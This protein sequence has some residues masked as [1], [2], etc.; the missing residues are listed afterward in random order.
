M[1]KNLK[2]VAAIV[3]SFAMAVQFGLADSYYVN[4]VEEPVEPQQEETTTAAPQEQEEVPTA[5]EETPQQ[6]EEQQQPA[7]EE[8]QPAPETKSVE[9]S[10]VAEDGTVLH[11][12]A[13]RDFN[14]DYSLK[15]DSSVMLNFDGYT[16]KDVIINNSQTVPA[17][18]ANLSVTSDL[19]SV[20]FVYVSVNTKEDKQT[21]ENNEQTKTEEANEDDAEA[22]PETKE[23][24]P[25]YPAFD[26]SETAGNVV[27]HATAAEGVLPRDSK[28]VVKR[29][30]RKAILNAV[31][32]TV[33]EKNKEMDSAVALD[34][35]IQNKDG[36]EIQPNGSVNISFENAAV[37]GDEINVYHV[38]DDASAVTEVATNTQSFD[39]NHFSIYVITGEKEKPLTTFNFVDANGKPVSTQIVKT[40]DTLITPTAPDVAGKAFVGWYEGETKFEDFNT[41]LTITETKTR[42]ITAKYENALYVYFY[43]PAGTQIMRTEKVGDHEVHGYTDVSYD[44]DS[45]HKLVG[46]AAERNGTENIA[47]KITVPKGSTSVNVYAIIKEGYWISFDSNG[48]S[49]VDSQFVLNGDKLV[50]NKSTTPTKPGYTF[51]GWYNDSTKVENGATVTNPMTLK[52]HWTAAEVNYTINYWQQ[53]VTDDKNATDAQK[54]YEYVEAVTEKATTGTKISATNSKTYKGFKYNANNSSKDVEIAGDGT[55]I[56]NV[57][58]DRVLCTVNFYVDKGGYYWSDW[59][60]TKTVTGL[61]GANLPEGA[62]DS[63]KNLWFTT[64]SYGSNAVLLTSFDFETAGYAK[65][66]DNVSENGIVTTCNFYAGS[67]LNGTIKYYNEQADGTFKLVQTVRT[68]GNSLTVHEKYEGYELYKYST[69]SNAQETAQYWNNRSSVKDKDVVNG[70]IINI[71]SK[72]KTYS[73]SYYNYNKVTKTEKSIKYTASLKSYAN[74]TPARPSELPDYYVFGGWYKDKAC[75]TKFDFN[76]EKMPNANVQIYAKWTAKKI[77]LTYN[78][79]TPDGTSKKVNRD[80]DAGTIASTV[81]PSASEI[82]G[83]S[84]AGWYYA[85]GNGHMTTKV[86]NANDAITKDTSVIGKWLY[87]GELTVVYDPGKEGTKATVPTDSN[88]YAGGAKVTVAKNATTTS[89]K[90]FLGWKLKGNLYH[91]GDA[92]EVNKDL[93]NDDNV[94][95]LTAIWGNEESSTT[96]SYNPG[97][98]RGIVQTVPVKNNESVTLKSEKDFGYQAPEKEGKEYYFAGWAT[99]MDDAN[100]G[101]ATY[102][103]GQTVHV[104]VNGEN[105]LYATW[106]EKT[107]ITLVANSNSVT[108]NGEAQSV[109]GF[110]DVADGYT[111]SNLTAKATGTNVGEYTTKIEGTAKVTKG[112]EDVTEKVVVNVVSGKLTISRRNVTL[113]SASDEKVYDGNALTNDTVTA[114]GFVEGQGATYNVTGTITNVGEKANAFEYS[115]NKGTKADNYNITK[116]EGTLKVTPVTDQVTVTITGNTGS[117]KYDGDSHEVTGYTTSFSNAL[118]TANDFEFNGTAEASR[119]DAGQTN[120]GLAAEQFTNT[121]ANFTNVEFVVTDGYS[122]VNKRTVTLT[123]ASDEKVYD[124]NALTKKKVTESEDGFAKGEGATYDVTGSQ[125]NVGSSKNTFT[126]TLNEGT[127][128]DNYEITKTEGTLKVTPI[129][130]Q[131]TVTI[132]GNT[133]SV[134]YDG[135]SHEVTGYTTSFSN[136]LYTAND[137]EFNGTAEASRT[138]AGQTDMGLAAEQFTNTSDNFTNVEFV[139][140]DGYSK[141]EKRNVTLTS[142]SDEK[143]YDGNPLTNGTV[144]AEGFVEGQGAT[145]GVT[146]S[147][148]DAGESKNTF[149]YTLNEGTNPDNYEIKKAEGTLKVTPVTDKVTVTITGNTDSVKYDGNSH[150]VTGYTTSF[151]NDLYTANDFEFSGTAEVNGKDADTYKMGLKKDQ[152]KNTSKNFTNVEFV[153]TDGQ[154]VIGKR[155][156]TLTSG[157]DSKIYNGKPLTNGEVTVTGDGFANGE[158]AAYNVTGTI[159]NVGETDNTFTY[160]LNKGTNPDNYEIKKAEG[161]LIVTADASEVVV[162]I[163]EN[164]ANIT[165][166]GNEHEAT[167]YTTSITGGTD[168]KEEDFTFNG[169][170]SVK[171]TDAG[172]YNMELKPEDFQNTNNNYSKVTFVI[173]DGTLTISKRNVTLTSASDE[174]VYD[175]NALTN[176][177]VTADGFVEGQG[178]T[179]N[180]TGTI[181][182]VGEKAN[183]FEYSLNKGTKADNYNI[184]KTEGTLKVT[185]VTDQVT[186]TITGNTGSV[187]YDGDSHEVTGYTTSFSNAL[188]TANDFEFNGTAEASRTD[189]GQTDMGLAAEQFT[190]TSDNFTNVEFV[191]TDGYSKVEKRNVTLTSASDEKVYD[192]NPLTNGTVTAE[193][194]V[195][196][197]GA[198]YKVTGTITNVG[199]KANA[200]AYTLNEGTNADNYNITKTEGT[201][202]VTPITDQVTVTITGNT[203]SVKYDGDSHEVTGYTTSFS[204]ALYTANDF[205]FNGTAEASRTDAGQTNMGL[206][207]EQFTNTS[208]NFTNVEFVVTDGYSKVN[209]RTVTLTSA[210]DEKVYDGNAL[211][212][213]KV[214]ESED[215]FAKGEGATYEFTGS[216]TNVGSSKN[217]FSYT[218]N[219]GTNAD[220]YE[221]TK[222][223]GTLKV[224][225]FTDKV[226]VTITGEKDTAVYDGKTHSVEGYKVTNISNALYKKADVQFNGTAKAEGIEV[227]TYTM[228][229]TPAQFENKSRNFANV[230]FVVNDGKLEITPKS[231]NPEDEKTGIKVTKPSDTMYNGEEQKNK[232]T[233][234]DTKTG[235]TL[236]E[237]VDYTLSYTAAVN[238]GTVEVT[239]TGIGNYTGTA[240]TSYEITKRKVTLT[241]GSASKVYDKKALT[242]DEVTVSG[243]GFAKNEGATYN[244]TGSRT[245]V[246]TSD[247]T[248]T[249]E[250]KSNTKASNYNI[251]VKFGDLIVTAQDGEVVVTITGHSDSAKYDG[252]EKT[253]SGYEVTITAGS[254]YK[255]DDFTFSGNAEVK[256]T[257]VGTY[258]MGLNAD[259][260]TNTNDNYTQVTFIVNDG[261]LTITPKS[262][263]PD[264]PNTPE[265]KKTGI[266]ATNPDDSIYNGEAHVNPLTV[267]DTKTGKDLVEN[268][269]YTLT[270]SD[271]VVNVGT[272]TVT[273]KGIGNYTGEFTKKYQITPREYTVTTDSAN[274]TYDGN[275]LTAGGTVNNLVKDETVVFTITGKQTDVGASDNTYELKFE[276]TAKAKNYTHGKDSIGQL[277]VTKK[278]IVPDGPDTPDEKKTGIKVTKPD[279]TMYNGK[280]QKNKP[281]VRDTKRDVELVEDT[282]YTL[283]YTAAVNAGTVTVTITGIGNYEGTVN[284]SYE[285]T[286]RKVIMTSAD[287]TKVYDGNALTKNKVT[288]SGNGF[289]EGEGATY[290]VTGSQTD[291][292]FS[293][294]TFSYKLNKGTLA[295][296]YTI[297]TKEG[298]LEVTPFTDKVTVTITGEKDTAVYDGKTHSVEGYKVTNISNALYKKADVQFNGTAKAEGIEVGTY[299]MKLTPAQFEN[300][301]RNF[302][303][304]EFVVNDGKLEITPKSINPEDEK[305]GI[306]VTKP[307][308]TMYNGE[309]QKNKPTV[310]DTKTG[311]TLVENVDYTLSYTAAVDA[312]TVEVTITGK[313]NYTGTAKT[314]YEITKRDVLLTSATDSKVYDKK[315][316]MN[317]K[318][319]ESGSGFVKD[320]GATYNVTGSQTKKGSTKN[321]F[322]YELK[323][324]T[325]ASNYTI[326]VVYGDLTVTAEDGE[327]V[328]VITGHKKSFE[329]DGN[330]KSVKGYDVSITKGSTYEVSDFTFNGNDE[331]K[332]TE[333]NTYPMGLKVS[334]FTNN[335]DNYNKVKF[336]VTD[337][338][339]TITPKSITP[340]GPN[341]P[342]EKKTGITATDPVDSI[343]DGKAHV[344]PLTVKDTKTNK[345]L[346]ENKDYTLTYSD[347]VVNVGTV[348]VTVKGI[349]NYTGE[350]TKKYQITPREY[351]VTTESANK[352]YDGTALT[353]GG[354]VNGLVEGETVSFKTTGSQTNEGTSDNTY[355]LKFKG[356]AVE[357]NY[358]HGKDSIGKLTV[359]KQS[360]DPGTDPEKPNPNYLGIEISN[361]SDEVYDGKEHKWSP[362]VVDKTG[363]ELIVGTDYAVE[364]ATSDFTNT[365]T[366]N[367]TITGIG[368]YTGKVTRTYS[369]TPREYTITTLDGTK[370]YDGKALTNFGLVDGIVYGETYSFKTTGSQTE[371]GTSDNTYEW[372]WNGTAKKSNY[373]L[374]KESIGKLTVKAKSIIPDGPDTPDEKK[375]GITV[376]EPSDSKY[377][378]KEHKEVLTVTDTKT[379]KELVAGTDYSVTYSS[380]LV[381]AGT[382]TMKVAGLGNYTGSFTKTY[383]ITK[384]S[385]TLTSATVS[386]VYDGSALTN[387]SITVSGDGFVEGEGASYEVT[388]TQTSVGNS[389]NAFEYKLNEK[390]LASNYNITKVVGTLTITAAPAPVTPATP[391]TSSTPSS[392]TSTTPRTPSAPQV[393]TPAETVEKETTPKAEPKKEEKVEEEYTPKASPQYYWALIN[394]I[395]AI[396]TVLFG[397]LLLISKRHKDEDDDEEDDETKQQTNND[398]EENEQEKKRGLFTRVLAVLIAIVSVVFF[399]VTE[400]LSLPWTWTD[401]WTIWMV[402]IGLVQIVVFF[403]GRK[404]KNV[405]NDDDDEEAQQA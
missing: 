250:L 321:T 332:G 5:E 43:N 225:P 267:R 125:T 148:T 65:N 401:Q 291:V 317:G 8:E 311:A 50:L 167:G 156:V 314:S 287:D 30:T 252:H 134:K 59:Q 214:T 248:F 353:A 150:K 335:N 392:T 380:D 83:Y 57:Y 307:S 349:G 391:S 174:K 323:S 159:T 54:T 320:E 144:T 2:K 309:E 84:F 325:K 265:D 361:P 235:A 351:T 236:V 12:T 67:G 201:L 356:T 164:S 14:L 154:L 205:E 3:L 180:V 185:P 200:F 37:S 294:N 187:K 75:T 368:N 38:T 64:K 364:Y 333:A 194:F 4:A 181:T 324:N 97:N 319:T 370:V 373:K 100:N 388:G 120:M 176:D 197:Q 264:G 31:E 298:R 282:D 88:I 289:V 21:S 161:K 212:K 394:L 94:I 189:A 295:S 112:S 108:Y 277:K 53:K 274:K 384:R 132:T 122:K 334:D 260:F 301:S 34:I 246:G 389:A 101:K 346:K 91:P 105:V 40:G 78:L 48:G 208:A 139:V 27:V 138:D 259:Q 162:T 63:S 276:G 61:Y 343:Y 103:A 374:A 220:N 147:Q 26:Q 387:T 261:T 204:N 312:G 173:V 179:Y 300:K 196:G 238:A 258:S 85:D 402:V 184:T 400:D 243:D 245:K 315:P 158:G 355:E 231:I 257:E 340:D 305:T 146:G 310:E 113:T 226:T 44:V 177:T 233:V 318:V 195:E 223:E 163:T 118:Y 166:D 92:F 228:K 25:E 45:T 151:S 266:T 160:T 376:S 183:A 363:K 284:T 232:P 136:A 170:A 327:V 249:Y 386:K 186:V 360:I 137:F 99:S 168:Y 217:T 107:V 87:N 109:E 190:N 80:V 51:N 253:V 215:G 281:V 142:A 405:D 304:V 24:L 22:D 203:G 58:Y 191:V 222:A 143:V 106:I 357:T 308:D 124:G 6:Q 393:T 326:E 19:V 341:T 375:T 20:K 378:G 302:A 299:T 127:N 306:K 77:N 23:E 69:G 175:G 42:T 192:G 135:D 337:G 358:K 46:W 86:F 131:V 230:E 71:A 395:C 11:E 367:V 280:E 404:W 116:T 328:V 211:T 47:D 81:L 256:G 13:S 29:I 255:T 268:K 385:V 239:I 193:G 141:V 227:G 35:T 133:G 290:D 316:L 207:A 397:L 32:D 55:T 145:Y 140:T 241:S 292:G 202:K 49:I 66:Q 382:V 104:D 359:K 372:K 362:T 329:Y 102:A 41:A 117:V 129:T 149:T 111:I 342:E 15:T 279:D 377:D 352:T 79:N 36:V 336:V 383:K 126:Y 199:E 348:T 229:L 379:G 16:L 330:E 18:Q 396:L 371:V 152:F 354:H 234:E 121:S 366:I 89:K 206:A 224:T 296:N 115:L 218:L 98:G 155:T 153:V 119:T 244:V 251:E 240:K 297:E 1:L 219:E 286:P 7:V 157:S 398:D 56:I 344:N 62:W 182:N 73:L 272:V 209:K 322:T 10:Y 72:L 110:G 254:T 213:K 271:D 216:Q 90:K 390:T 303:N 331:V 288:E 165:Y 114:D 171:G 275:P 28:L 365:G 60:I 221:I 68:N 269:D 338:S 210:S 263:V 399:L 93:A 70:N 242:K 247:N 347:D 270:Y 39:A 285:I 369:I 178:A 96:M 262:I 123:S 278:S 9:L 237:N 76:T 17:D 403:V 33:S 172:T 169:N 381:N 198:T 130:N 52:A 345:D 283:S 95:T 82:E 339:L 74:Y 128:A 350:F 273:V 293:N 313:G 188:Y